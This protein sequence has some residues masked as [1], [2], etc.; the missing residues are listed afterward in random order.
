MCMGV[1]GFWFVRKGW[2][3]GCWLKVGVRWGGC[4]GLCIGFRF[5]FGNIIFTDIEFRFLFI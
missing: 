5:G 4:L 1:Y 2:M 3:N